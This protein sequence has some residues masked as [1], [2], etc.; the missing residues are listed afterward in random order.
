MTYL[1][2][3]LTKFS[4]RHRQRIPNPPFLVYHSVCFKKILLGTKIYNALVKINI[5]HYGLVKGIQFRSICFEQT[6]FNYTCSCL[7]VSPRAQFICF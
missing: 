6:L 2:K 5:I 1:G 4:Q 7:S 3:I